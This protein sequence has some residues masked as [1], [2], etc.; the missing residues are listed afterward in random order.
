MHVAIDDHSRVAYV[1]MLGADDAK[2][3]TAFFRR[4]QRWFARQKIPIRRVLTDNGPGYISHHFARTCSELGTRH[5]FTKPYRPRTNGKAERL[6]Q[7]LLREC[8]YRFAY[9]SSHQRREALNR[10]LHFYNH[11]RGHSSLNDNAPTSRLI[12]NNV[13]RRDN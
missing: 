6:I 9:D 7:T 5:A 3:A 8:I 10:Y 12:G 2:T 13:M 11:H 1:E 4:A